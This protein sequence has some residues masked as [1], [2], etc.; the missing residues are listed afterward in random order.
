MKAIISDVHGNLEALQA[1]LNDIAA[2]GVE[3]IYCLG[4]IIDYGP[5]PRECIDLLMGCWVVLQGDRDQATLF[6][7]AGDFGTESYQSA[8]WTRNELEQ[9]TLPEE[10]R[11]RRWDFLADCPQSHRDGEFLFVHGSPINPL[12]GG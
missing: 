5:N 2:H 9:I 4:D 11:K 8:L 3:D 6:D 7:E 1:V 10:E 12:H